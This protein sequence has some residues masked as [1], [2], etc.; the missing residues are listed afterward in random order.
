MLFLPSRKFFTATDVSSCTQH[1]RKTKL[2]CS[3]QDGLWRA[4]GKRWTVDEGKLFSPRYSLGSSF[5]LHLRFGPLSLIS[6]PGALQLPNQGQHLSRGLI[7][8]GTVNERAVSLEDKIRV[9]KRSQCN[10][11]SDTSR[12]NSYTTGISAGDNRGSK[13]RGN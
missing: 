1:F 11:S 3:R 10:G 6:H 13:N 8:A 4:A 7:P 2:K 5:L 9:L 12:A